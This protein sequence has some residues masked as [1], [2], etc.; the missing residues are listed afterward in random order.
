MSADIIAHNCVKTR[1][2]FTYKN[3]QVVASQS[4]GGRLMRASVSRFIYLSQEF[5]YGGNDRVR[6]ILNS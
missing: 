6:H 3:L 4:A 2:S 5:I 1:N